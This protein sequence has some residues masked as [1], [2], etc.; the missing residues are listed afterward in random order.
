[1][2]CSEVVNLPLEHL[3]P[4]VFTNELHYIQLILEAGRVPGQPRESKHQ[5]RLLKTHEDASRNSIYCCT[6]RM[7]MLVYLSM[8]PCP[9][10]KPMLSR[11]ETQTALS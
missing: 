7:C 1:M 5:H 2:V 10:L 6:Y 3:C 4:E 11:T 8:S 9:T